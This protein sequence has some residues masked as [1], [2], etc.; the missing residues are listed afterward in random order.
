MELRRGGRTRRQLGKLTSRNGGS[1]G[2]GLLLLLLL[3][4]GRLDEPCLRGRAGEGRRA[5]RSRGLRRPDGGHCRMKLMMMLVMTGGIRQWLLLL[6][7]A[8]GTRN[9]QRLGHGG[10]SQA[11]IDRR[12]Q[13]YRREKVLML[14][15]LLLLLGGVRWRSAVSGVHWCGA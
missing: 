6:V 4:G 12:E 5:D 10:R 7:L 15:L 2:L 11:R 14:L 3:C 8:G 13:L 9:D 1:G